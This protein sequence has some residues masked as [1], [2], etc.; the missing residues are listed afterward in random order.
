MPAGIVIKTPNSGRAKNP[1]GSNNNNN[2]SKDKDHSGSSGKKFVQTRLPFKLITPVAAAASS[3]STAATSSSTTAASSVDLTEDAV[4]VEREPR[5][6][7]LSYGVAKDAST[8]AAGEEDDDEAEALSNSKENQLTT[9]TTISKK[10]KTQDSAEDGDCIELIDDDDDADEEEEVPEV[11]VKAKAKAK[12]EVKQQ[13]KVKAKAKQET[14]PTTPPVQIKLPLHNKRAKRRK[15][16]KKTETTTATQEETQAQVAP[17]VLEVERSDSSDDIEAIAEQLNPQKRAKVLVESKMDV[18]T[19][20]TLAESDSEPKA[21]KDADKEAKEPAEV[22]VVTELSSTDVEPEPE[23][24]TEQKTSDD[25]NVAVPAEKSSTST[26]SQPLTAKQLKLQEQRR[27]AREEKER[28]LQEER[29]QKQQEKE[30]REQQ[31]KAEREQKEEQRRKEREDKEQVRR[32]EREEKERKR[33]AEVDKKDEE[34]R[35]RNEAKEEVQR[36]KDEERRR[37]ELEKEEAELKKKRAAASF[38]KFFVPK[39]PPRQSTG[40]I[41]GGHPMDQDQNSCDSNG[42]ANG[43]SQTLAFRPFQIKDDMILAPVIRASIA[44]DSRRQLDR[45]F[46]DEDEYDEDEDEDMEDLN[47][48]IG[49]VKRPTRAQLYVAELTQGRHKPLCSKRDVRLQRRSKDEE[50]EDD[51]QIVD[52][53][54]NA[55]TPIVQ[56]RAKQVPWVRA[57][58]LHFADNRRPPFYGTWRKRSQVINA[59]RPLGQDKAYFD[60]EVDSDCEWEEEEPGESLS[61]SEDEKERESEEESE[62]EYNEWFVPHGHLSDEELQNDDELEDGNTREAQK[63]KLQVLQQEFAQEMKKQTK[64]IKP[65]L[66]GPVWLDENGNKS[67]LFPA[68]FAQTIDMYGCWQLEPLTLEPP[69]EVA[70]EEE[71]LEAAKVPKQVLQMDDRL[72]QQLVRLIHGNSNSKVFLIAEYL[73]YLKTQITQESMTLPPKTLLREKFDELAAWKSVVVDPNGESAKKSKKPRK[74]L[75]WVVSEEILQKYELSDLPIL[76]QWS[77]K[78]TPKVGKADTSLQEPAATAAAGDE[79]Q[80]DLS[81]QQ[82]KR[83]ESLPSTPTTAKPTATTS[84]STATTAAA[85][86]ATPTATAASGSN[87]K[88]ATLLMSVGRDQQFHTPTKN[89]LISQYL[90]KQNGSESKTAKPSKPAPSVES[91]DDVVLLSD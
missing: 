20:E 34:K 82:T 8:A 71:P 67:E 15:S 55:G 28:K 47:E 33:Q 66:L 84:P 56:E 37:K 38:T 14:A 74:R 3:G 44:K 73:E 63:A 58:Y 76:N 75:S 86:A 9:T 53:L 81:K 57:K 78:L 59:R 24:D 72:L 77:Y 11:K 45:L 62:E 43:Q 41:G 29:N 52:E 31:R 5:K 2:N 80:T 6:R 19:D 23:P 25:K 13:P 89:A 17:P 40:S 30:Q 46:R 50:D 32:Q 79:Q 83:G 27:K 49:R 68:V 10:A 69:P 22:V 18:D 64:K 48:S 26:S 42:H 88:R 35:K 51:V 4:V 1:N 12:V 65:R 39:Q 60:Y 54:A 36:K 91:N 90:R 21:A 85:A 7:K 16:L 70:G 87:K 61:A